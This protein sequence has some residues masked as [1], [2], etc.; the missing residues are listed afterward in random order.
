MDVLATLTQDMKDMLRAG[1]KRGLEAVRYL[2]AQ[3]KNA[4]IDK[5]NH[6]AL[7]ES[8]FMTIVRKVLKNTEEAIT[9]YANGGRTDLVE[10]E[11]EK[12]QFM[13]KYLPQQLGEDELRDLV[14]QII[15]ENPGVQPGPLTGKVMQKVAGRADGGTVSRL[16]REL[17]S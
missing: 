10:E 5:P 17:T 6:E 15:A 12:M 14:S 1:N 9:Q 13:K 7:T 11:T 8:E 16:I 2:L 4:Q 3:V